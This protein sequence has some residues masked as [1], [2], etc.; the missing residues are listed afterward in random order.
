[1][2]FA[3]S[4][5]TLARGFTLIEMMTSIVVLAVILA[6]AVPNLAGFVRTSRVRGAPRQQ[7]AHKS[8]G[9]QA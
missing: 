3:P 2:T 1:M 8:F 9:H 6:I 5:R 4:A 7:I